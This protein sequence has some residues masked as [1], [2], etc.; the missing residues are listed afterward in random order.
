M[1]CVSKTV[2][3]IIMKNYARRIYYTF[4][5]CKVNLNICCVRLVFLYYLYF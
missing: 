5:T 3:V 1:L 2:K 4:F